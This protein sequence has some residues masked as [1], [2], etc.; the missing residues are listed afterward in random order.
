MKP[1]IVRYA[2]DFVAGFEHKEDA[3]RFLTDLEQRLKRFGL[4]LHPDK[5]RCIEFGR[6]ALANRRARG[7]RRP[8]TFD[9]LGSRTIA[10]PRAKDGSGSGGSLK[11]SE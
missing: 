6:Y 3:E 5:T 9:F 2:D 10:E 4:A 11:R 1:V 8:K 7:E